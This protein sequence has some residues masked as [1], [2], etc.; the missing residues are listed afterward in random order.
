MVPF[1]TVILAGGKSTRMGRDKALIPFQGRP[2]IG[3]AID[4]AEALNSPVIISANGHH[5]DHLGFPVRQ[6]ILPVSAPLAGIHA[7]L[8]ASHTGWNLV[9]TCDMPYV[10]AGLIHRLAFETDDTVRMVLP[11]HNGFIE[12]LCGFWHRELLPVIESLAGRGILKLLDVAGAVAHRI[13]SLD[14]VPSEELRKWF[15]NM[16][17]IG[18]LD[19]TG[20]ND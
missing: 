16:N 20:E 17:R 4:L 11:R 13:V 8:K 2:L 14:D 19:E 7:G 1:T 10:P 9:L 15:S 12:P 18:D 6:D 3:Y 5:L